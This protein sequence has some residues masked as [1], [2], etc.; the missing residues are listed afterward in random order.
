MHAASDART[1]VAV[2][3]AAIVLVGLAGTTP[4]RADPSACDQSPFDQRFADELRSRWPRNR[5]SAE[6]VDLRTGCTYAFRPD[7]RMTTASVFK[8]EAMAGVLLRA[9]Q[10]HRTVTRQEHDLLGPMI[11]QSADPPASTLYASLGGPAGLAR[12]NG[13]FGMTATQPAPSTWGLTVTSARDQ[14]HLVRQLLVGDVGPFNGASRKLAWRYMGAV[15]PS[16]QWG[17]GEALPP[18]A[19]FGMKNGF[20]GSQCCGWRINTVGYVSDPR[21]GG[22]VE[23]V[24]TDGWASEAAGRQAMSFVVSAMH[25]Q[26]AAAPAGRG[27][28]TSGNPSPAPTPAPAG[29]PFVLD[30]GA[31][32]VAVVFTPD[33]SGLWILNGGGAVHSEGSATDHGGLAGMRLNGPPIGIEATP[34]GGGYWILG[35]DGGVFAFGDARYWGSTGAVVLN[36]PIVSM[37]TTPTGNGYWL[38]G[39][40]GGVFAYGDA[41]FW[42]S[43]GAMRLAQP[44]VSMA[45]TPSGDGYWLV[46]RDGGVFAFGAARYFGSIPGGG[47]CWLGPAVRIR[48]TTTGQGYWILTA[49]GRITSFGDAKPIADGRSN[50]WPRQ[51]GAVAFAI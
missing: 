8:V 50:G 39:A 19:D 3:V 13:I 4:A 17:V 1:K 49:D 51:P 23:A 11:T 28:R 18:G 36:A 45:A 9:Q 32:D 29:D 31:G 14:A 40:D 27:C 47:D 35:Q 7:L 20:A 21:G 30:G 38:L 12:L 15:V 25:R 42:G 37:A 5:F 16:Q 24:L 10:Q 6:V 48:P 43:T 22:W 41:P 2:V 33:R 44:I 26:L 34:S 46:G